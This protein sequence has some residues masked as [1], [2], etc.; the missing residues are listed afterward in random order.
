MNRLAIDPARAALEM[1]DFGQRMAR[2]AALVAT[3]DLRAEAG[4]PREESLRIGRTVLWRYR[5]QAPA[6]GAAPLVICYALVN[7]PTM[8]DLQPD[9]SLIRALLARGLDVW[10]VDWGYPDAG[11][12]GLS[13]DDYVNRM[14]G[15]CLDQVRRA[16]GV[17]A[18]NL[19]GVCQGG[20]LSLCHAALHPERVQNLVLMVTPVDFRTPDNL[21]SKWVQHVDVERMVEVLGNV[22]GALLN[23]AFLS[24][25]PLRLTAQ[26]YAGLADI[27]DDREALANFLRME[28]WIQ[29]SP[30][31]A[32]RA[33]AEFVRSFFRENR[34]LRGGLTIGGRQVDL[35]RIRCPVLN[36]FAT[37]DHLVPPAASRALAGLTGSPDYSEFA[38]DGGHIGIYVSR[39][40]QELL[41]AKIAQW[42]VD[43]SATPAPA[44]G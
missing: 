43:R 42:L 36:V 34:L 26:K 6:A 16:C 3:L 4:A 8:M 25:M 18:V 38:F 17:P 32:G 7:R 41:P 1:A 13:L 15:A 11:D 40:A 23:A 30:D 22:P 28:R 5:A 37:R 31:Q 35:A 9:R 20:T 39:R 10:L 27:A 19:L 33:F 12:R 2:A 44:I 14:L 24:L 21:L 29:D